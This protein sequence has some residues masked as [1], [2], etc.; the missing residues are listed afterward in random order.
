VALNQPAPN[1]RC[2]FCGSKLTPEVHS[3]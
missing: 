1:L 3:Q 2:R